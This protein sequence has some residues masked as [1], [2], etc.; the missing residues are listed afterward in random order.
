MSNY[1]LM[2]HAVDVEQPPCQDA[3]D[4]HQRV[5]EHEPLRDDKDP[6]MGVHRVTDLFVYAGSH[7]VVSLLDL[8]GHRPVLPE[9]AVG[10]DKEPQVEGKDDKECETDRIRNR[11]REHVKVWR[12]DGNHG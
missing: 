12:E 3:E 6:E 7:Q 1:F 10:Q 11:E 4:E 5:C 8:E 9:I 2:W